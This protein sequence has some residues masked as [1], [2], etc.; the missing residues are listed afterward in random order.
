M[1][2]THK[3]GCACG[4]VAGRAMLSPSAC[5]AF[6]VAADSLSTPH[7]L[8]LRSDSASR[9]RPKSAAE[10]QWDP[11]AGT[12]SDGFFDGVDAVIHL[13]AIPRDW[14]GGRSL[15]RINTGGTRNIVD[16]AKAAGV[17]RFI[18][19]GALA[20][21]DRPE[22]HYAS[23][24]KRAERYV[25]ESGLDWTIVKPSLIWGP[26]DG[27]FNI[28]A[29]LV[30]MSPGFVPVPGDGKARFQPIAAT[31]VARAF[32]L[33]LEDPDA[34]GK[35]FLI[36]GPTYTPTATASS[37]LTVT[38]AIAPGSV[39][40]IAGGIVSFTAAGTCTINASQAGNANYNAATSVTQTIVVQATQGSQT[41]TFPAAGPIKS[42]AS[43][44]G[45]VYTCDPGIVAVPGACDNL[46]GGAVRASG[47][48]SPFGRLLS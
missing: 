48:M 41:I 15:A 26:R 3:G 20:V 17:R 18:H 31:D 23:S 5:A 40:V 38:F 45:I 10:R 39:C 24:K 16:A 28:L 44:S 46:V 13:V 42:S 47:R 29:G 43:A 2:T 9:N 33:C 1:A 35:E 6:M 12:L 11:A 19:Q 4:S 27:F 7:R 25:A 30:R 14:D 34:V 37:G 36:G 32:R 8:T 21:E 22:L